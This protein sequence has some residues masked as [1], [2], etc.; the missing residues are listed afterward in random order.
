M[1]TDTLKSVLPFAS[2]SDE[3]LAAILDQS[4]DCIKVLSSE[5]RVEYMNR[6]GQ[7]AMEIDDFGT[8]AG[9]EWAEL[10][11]ADARTAIEAALAGA[12]AT[13][14]AQFSAFCST[15]KGTPKWWDVSV[16]ALKLG[17]GFAGFVS[18]SRDITGRVEAQEASEAVAAEMRH[19]LRNAYQVAGGLMSILARGVPD[20]Q[21]FAQD[22]G[23][24]LAALGA[25]QTL[26]GQ[27][28]GGDLHALVSAFVLPY[29]TPDCAVVV[30]ALPSA[31]L[32]RR[33]KE[34]LAMV[35]GELAVN[36]T[37]HGGL[38]A[39]GTVRIT[40]ARDGDDAIHL[41]WS[42][43]SDRRVAARERAGGNGMLLMTRILAACGG[44]MELSWEEDGLDARI[45]LEI[46][47]T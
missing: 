47:P 22:M 44:S 46:T 10:W 20:R 11:P 32:N 6:A 25:A 21:A 17:E 45:T 31:R 35:F 16:K 14:S 34:A 43:R 42:E 28:D 9:R 39:R 40:G 41:S 12:L 1:T 3:L 29:A 27:G 38:S 36:S 2:A 15:A 23:R 5:G 13:G 19:R 24:R 4:P 33:Q 18:I 26:D 37:K 8:I 30:E 7:C